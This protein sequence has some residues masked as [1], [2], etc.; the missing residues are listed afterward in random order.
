MPQNHTD[1]E[2]LIII[3]GTEFL[4]N[5]RG[6]GYNA[7]KDYHPNFE[8]IPFVERIKNMEIEDTFLKR[9]RNN[10]VDLAKLNPK[11]LKELF[12]KNYIELGFYHVVAHQINKEVLKNPI[13]ENSETKK[14]FAIVLLSASILLSV[15]SYIYFVTKLPNPSVDNPKMQKTLREMQKLQSEREIERGR[16][17]GK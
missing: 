10:L 3:R 5:F 14:K 8:I 9:F 11:K 13:T 12:K 16:G 7:I 2:K 6:G 4:E 1:L 17:G 15:I